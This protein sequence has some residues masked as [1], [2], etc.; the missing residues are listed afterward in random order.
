MCFL[1]SDS[2]CACILFTVYF[3]GGSSDWSYLFPIC[4][5][6]APLVLLITWINY[7]GFVFVVVLQSD[8]LLFSLSGFLIVSSLVSLAGEPLLQ[9]YVISR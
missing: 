9:P 8:H 1:G 6:H 5:V 2:V 7:L 3:L 4:T